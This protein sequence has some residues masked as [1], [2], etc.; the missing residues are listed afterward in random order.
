MSSS[1]TKMPGFALGR[2]IPS[3]MVQLTSN[4]GALRGRSPGSFG[5]LGDAR[6]GSKGVSGCSC[7]LVSGTF[8][9]PKYVRIL[10]F[11]IRGKGVIFLQKP[12]DSNRTLLDMADHIITYIYQKA[13]GNRGVCLGPCILYPISSK[14]CCCSMST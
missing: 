10:I 7:F 11:Q 13:T 8:T 9:I 5:N 3:E 12:L 4:V 14:S 1:F 6:L 2:T